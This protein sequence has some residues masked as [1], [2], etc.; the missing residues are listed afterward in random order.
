[1]ERRNFLKTLGTIGGSMIVSKKASAEESV[2]EEKEFCGILVDTTRCAGCQ[3]CSL[4]CAE[5]HGL[6]EPDMDDNLITPDRKNTTENWTVIRGVESEDDITYIKTQCMHCN[7]PA[8]AS[9]CP[10]K[11]M[12]KTEE[13]PVIWHS[14]RC[15]GCRFCMLSC[16][17]DVPKFEYNSPVPKIQKCIMC[18]E[19]LQEGEEPACTEACP[20]DAITF[21]KRRELIDEA[22]TR[23]Y[24]SPD[25]YVHHIYGQNEAGGTGYMYLASVPFEKLGFKTE[26]GNRAYP[27]LTTDFLYGVPFVLT[28][29]PAM[30]IALNKAT[31]KDSSE[32]ED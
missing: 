24:E 19:R 5:A 22:N 29:W 15:M 25:D 17:F 1:M 21:G 27:E 10:T 26:I 2:K 16:P 23:I 30:L 12:E 3:E 20:E 28:L 7:Q 18:W 11:A 31:K 6:P 14:D 4:A 9:A 32:E 8:C 13:G